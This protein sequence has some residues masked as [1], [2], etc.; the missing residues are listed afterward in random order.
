MVDG[1]PLK[2]TNSVRVFMQPNNGLLFQMNQIF[3]EFRVVYHDDERVT[4]SQS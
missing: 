4:V 2:S 3:T 1:H